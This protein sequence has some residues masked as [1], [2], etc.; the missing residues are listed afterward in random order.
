[1]ARILVID[2]S[3]SI[4]V[5]VS[6]LLL[7]AGHQVITASSGKQGLATLRETPI[8]LVLTDIYMPDGDGIEILFEV[9]KAHPNIPVIVMSSK[10]DTSNMFSTAKALGAVFALQKPFSRD[11]LNEMIASGLKPRA[12]RKPLVVSYRP[13]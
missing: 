9:R 4:L 12:A 6:E 8:D 2:D 13:S 1:M 5:L 7:D 3:V 11:Q 10:S